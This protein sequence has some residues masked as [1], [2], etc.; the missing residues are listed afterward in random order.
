[1]EHFH[2][3]LWIIHLDVIV[4]ILESITIPSQK[5]QNV[6]ITFNN[7]YFLFMCY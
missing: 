1:M 3:G 5:C 6:C 2:G 7:V 4:N